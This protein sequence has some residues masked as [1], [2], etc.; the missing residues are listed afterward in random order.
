MY[1]YLILFLITVFSCSTL[2]ESFKEESNK[3]IDEN[4]INNYSE[5]EELNIFNDNKMNNK[6]KESPLEDFLKTLKNLHLKY[7]L[8]VY[9]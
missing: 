4:T 3:D 9:L 6:E 5:K 1:K 8:M 7:L 2:F